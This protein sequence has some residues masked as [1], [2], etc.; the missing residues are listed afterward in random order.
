MLVFAH[1]GCHADV[2]ENT[3]EAIAAAARLGVHGV[4]VDVRPSADGLAVLFHDPASPAGLR[5]R[6]ASRAE[7]SA[8]VGYQVP[9]LDEALTAFP[10]LEWDIE[11]KSAG[12]LQPALEAIAPHR[13][14]V[15][16]TFT[17]FNHTLAA[18]AGR[19]AS[20]PFGYLVARPSQR[21][22]PLSRRHRPPA[23][24]IVW[25]FD[26]PTDAEVRR[27]RA[28]GLRTMLYGPVSPEDHAA[29]REL[30]VDAVITDFPELLLD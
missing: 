7:L 9:T 13:A 21:P 28:R 12:A 18:R 22:G 10:S 30:D 19:L 15:R 16:I 29:C 17:S 4:E 14:A 25:R 5:V 1:R 2:P 11:L 20:L 6:D 24:A 26:V 27:H 8:A 23:S 3:L